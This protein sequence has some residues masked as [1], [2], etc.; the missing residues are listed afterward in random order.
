MSINH[1]LALKIQKD[2]LRL[3]DLQWNEILLEIVPE[4]PE[5]V[6]ETVYLAALEQCS[7]FKPTL[8]MYHLNVAQA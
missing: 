6:L 1:L 2:D 4:P 8:N 3:Y 5:K 7:Q